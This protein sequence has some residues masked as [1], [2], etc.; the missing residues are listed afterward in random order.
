[1]E[2]LPTSGVLS[3]ENKTSDLDKA[4]VMRCRPIL[5]STEM[6][7]AIL[8]GRKTQTRR[9]VKVQP[10]DLEFEIDNV[11]RDWN[12][13]FKAYP[14]EADIPIWNFGKCPFGEP[15]D[16]LWVR[17]TMIKNDG[18]T[19][20]PVADGYKKNTHLDKTIP[21]IHMPKIAC[22]LFLKISAQRIERLHKIS[23][24]DAIAEG[25]TKPEKLQRFKKMATVF[26][27]RLWKRIYGDGSWNENPFVWVIE[28]EVCE[29]PNGFA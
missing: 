15:G 21:S 18:F 26:F 1:M 23:E 6:V 7:Q 27:S 13:I 20:W 2:N 22:R 5:F 8:L 3:D 17:E 19:Y 11:C 25:I 9:V 16:I 24:D 14:K 29:R 10:A 28:F 12:Y 4:A